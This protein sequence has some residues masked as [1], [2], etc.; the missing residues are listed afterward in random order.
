LCGHCP[1]SAIL[2]GMNRGGTIPSNILGRYQTLK[3]QIERHSRLYYV[4]ARTE[5]SD[6]EFDALM[7]ELETLEAQYP[8]LRTPDSPTQRVGGEP[9]EGFETVVHRVP[10]LSIDNTYNAAELR[11]FDERVRRGL[12]GESPAYVVEL[13]IDGVAMSL[14]YEDRVLVRAA[15][16]GD[17]VRGDDVT[18]N[19]RTI[20]SVPLRL[21]KGA[22]AAVEV[23][24]EVFMR[25]PELERLNKLREEADEE[26][27]RNPRN[28]AAG[29]LKLKDPKQVAQ[30]RLEMFF[31][32]LAPIEDVAVI[33]HR[34]TL[35]RLHAWGFPVNP[36]HQFCASIE[37]VL[38]ACALW[39]TKRHELDYETDG[40]VVKVDS[41][42]HRARLGATSKSPRWIIAYKFPAE[43]ARTRLKAIK[44]QVGKSGA[45][46]P[47]AE[48]DPVKLA[49]TIVKRAT[50]HNFEELAKKDLRV[51]DLVEVQK[52]GEIIPQVLRFIP[53]ERPPEAE[54]CPIPAACPECESP[55]YKDPEGVFYRCLNLACPAQLKQRLEHFAQRRALDIDGLGEA[56]IKQLV[57]KGLVRGPADLYALDLATLSG[58]ERMAGKSASNLLAALDASK[59][60]PLSRLLFGLGVRHVG[61]HTAEILAQY[62]GTM[63]KVMAAPVEEL[64]EI[65]DIG[66][67]VA[68]SI[69][70]FFEVP[71]NQELI[72]RLRAAGLRM[73]EEGSMDAARPRPWSGKTFVVTGTLTRYTREEIHERIKGLGGKAA[74]SVSKK[75]DYLVA[76]ENAGSKLANAQKLGVRIVSE[77]EFDALLREAS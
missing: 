76:G 24:G 3:T 63:D 34:D 13:K 66:P 4:E 10:M 38:D 1:Y 58:L 60:R 31:Y 62:Y 19:V 7:R 22:P 54:P 28:T 9:V 6:L 15:T 32:E 57:D 39:Q 46:T 35:K 72:A 44:V 17:G 52:A 55:V 36:H 51:G 59:S 70:G 64:E 18:Q 49:G 65:E 61:R 37:A 5:I 67:V 27:F 33:S 50:L 30:R 73:E 45:L 26:P 23:R 20:H 8:E 42:A 2:C 77:E 14:R 48:M 71:E 29:T 53:E 47:V 16:R 68:A 74:T 40:M 41:A 56:L 12:G 21:E 43:I 75:T 25:N 11:A 69:H